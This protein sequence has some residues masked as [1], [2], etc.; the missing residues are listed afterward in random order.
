[1]LHHDI[2]SMLANGFPGESGN[3]LASRDSLALLR[4]AHEGGEISNYRVGRI[5]SLPRR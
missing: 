2:G 3:K 4:K 1:M 5:A